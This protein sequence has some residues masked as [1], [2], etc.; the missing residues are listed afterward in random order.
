MTYANEDR[1]AEFGERLC[2]RDCSL[3]F[4]KVD[5]ALVALLREAMHLDELGRPGLPEET[6]TAGAI[7]FGARRV[8]VDPLARVICIE[9]VLHA[10]GI[11]A[12]SAAQAHCYPVRLG[13]REIPMDGPHHIEQDLIRRVTAMHAARKLSGREGADILAGVIVFPVRALYPFVEFIPPQ[14]AV[15]LV[16]RCIGD[17]A[18]SEK[19][20]C[21][22]RR[23]A[24]FGAFHCFEPM[25]EKV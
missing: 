14:P 6:G 25:S 9:E 19:R 10:Y 3:A 5:P 13:E 20:I 18:D 12:V 16:R 11:A 4:G 15:G 1:D 2:R 22:Q 7:T 8:H 17:R 23:G 24:A 21:R